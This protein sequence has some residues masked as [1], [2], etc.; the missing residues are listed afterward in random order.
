MRS[1]TLEL[2]AEQ[3]NFPSSHEDPGK[4]EKEAGK[5]Q[6]EPLMVPLGNL[7]LADASHSWSAWMN[8]RCFRPISL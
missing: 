7:L 8:C 1:A 4:A 2:E 6:G 5:A 3:C